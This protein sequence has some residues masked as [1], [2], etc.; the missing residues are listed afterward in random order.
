MLSI[1]YTLRSCFKNLLMF[2][3]SR[4]GVFAKFAFLGL[5]YDKAIKLKNSG[6]QSAGEVCYQDNLF[7]LFYSLN[8]I[9]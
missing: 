3:S 1:L 6:N 8:Y 2:L 7:I 9:M 4:T 5:V